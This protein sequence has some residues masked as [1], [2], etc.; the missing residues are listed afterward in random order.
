MTLLPKLPLLVAAL[1][2]VIPALEEVLTPLVSPNGLEFFYHINNGAKD[3]MMDYTVDSCRTGFTN[4]QFARIR[5][6]MSYYRG[7]N[8]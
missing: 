1:L 7:I 5:Q 4:G 3:N 6:Q 8:I 2:D